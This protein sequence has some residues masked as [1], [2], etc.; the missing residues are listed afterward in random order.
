M[1]RNL[2]G[3][4]SGPEL[5]A[6]AEALVAVLPY[7]TGTPTRMLRKLMPLPIT[8]EW[9]EQFVAND[10]ELSLKWGSNE[11]LSRGDSTI[12]FDFPSDV[13][14]DAAAIL[15]FLAPLPLELFVLSPLHDYWIENDYY[16]P[17]IGADHALLGSGMLFKGAGH[18]HS[19]VSRRWLEHGPFRT[20]RGPEDTTLAQFHD[21][22]ADGP[23]SLEQVQPAHDWIVAGFL[24]PKHRFQHDIKGVYTKEDRLLRILVNDRQVTDEEL[25]D[26]CAARRDG[27]DD[28][29]KPIDNIAYVFVDEGAA[30]EQLEALWLRGL[31]CRVA[32]GRGERRLDADYQPTIKRPAWV[33][34]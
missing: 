33:S 30:R 7:A 26:A 28:P 1:D 12:G 13:A 22:A 34:G 9:H 11:V 29:A 17:A 15:K 24:R 6:L 3:T 16:A 32:D 25:L 31:E 8:D 21:F 23:T 5:S 18:E 14:V 20:I 19:L 10:A 4:A 27:R 2:G